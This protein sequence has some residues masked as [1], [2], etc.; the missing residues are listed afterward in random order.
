MNFSMISTILG[1]SPK[2]AFGILILPTNLSYYSVIEKRKLYNWFS[3][4]LIKCYYPGSEEVTL[5]YGEGK[6]A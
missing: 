2:Y 4:V 3:E 5:F 6:R 1:T